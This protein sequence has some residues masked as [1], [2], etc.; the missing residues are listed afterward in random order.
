MD[1]SLDDIATRNKRNRSKRGKAEKA[2]PAPYSA[3]RPVPQAVKIIASNLPFNVTS[4]EAKEL[5]G[6]IG[7]SPSLFAVLSY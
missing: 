3:P 5:F 2:R 4:V 7:M 6:T 1:M